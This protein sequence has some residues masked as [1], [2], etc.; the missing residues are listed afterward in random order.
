MC[1]TWYIILNNL[2][3]TCCRRLEPFD[4]AATSRYTVKASEGDGSSVQQASQ[5]PAENIPQNL[6][7]NTTAE[8]TQILVDL[9]KSNEPDEDLKTKED[10]ARKAMDAYDKQGALF[11]SSLTRATPVDILPKPSVATK[12]KV[13]GDTQSKLP[14]AIQL[15]PLAPMGHFT[16][17]EAALPPIQ[18]QQME[19]SQQSSLETQQPLQFQQNA[20]TLGLNS[21][22]SSNFVFR[23][24]TAGDMTYVANVLCGKRE[25]PPNTSILIAP[26]NVSRIASIVMS[27]TAPNNNNSMLENQLA[28][29]RIE[30]L[31]QVNEREKEIQELRAALAKMTAQV[32]T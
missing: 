28:N 3:I 19:S 15:K 5:G 23:P 30:L 26:E 18:Q 11:R 16:T 2:F 22:P 8:V 20:G 25:F 14:V 6:Q 13:P 24:Y 17:A 31:T 21:N 27:T 4:S 29:D 9:S 7:S 12:P 10:S 32:E 1:R